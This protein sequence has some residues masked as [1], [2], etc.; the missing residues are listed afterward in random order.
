VLAAAP[1]TVSFA[2]PLAGRPVVVV[3][4][5][6]G[7]RTTYE[8]VEPRVRP[9]ARVVGAAVLGTLVATGSHCLPACLHWGA[10]R[11][12]AYLDPLTLLRPR[13]PAVLLPLAELA[14][15]R[16]AA[17]RRPFPRLTGP[18]TLS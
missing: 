13:T 17:A 3:L 2:G 7:I 18:A 16:R 4:H 10:L 6:D 14:G 9:G 15:V 12:A 5:V 8:P 11:G 1:G